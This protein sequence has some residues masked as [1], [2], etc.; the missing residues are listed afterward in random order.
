M[1]NTTLEQQ[2]ITFIVSD[3]SNGIKNLIDTGFNL[4]TTLL[5]TYMTPL[6]FAAS[7]NSLKSVETLIKL[8]ANINVKDNTIIN[9]DESNIDKKSLEILKKY[10][11]DGK[12]CDGFSVL[13]LSILRKH[14]K[15]ANMLIE[16]GADINYK[17]QDLMNP[18]IAAAVVDNVEIAEK[19]LFSSGYISEKRIIHSLFLP[20]M[21]ISNNSFHF[22]DFYL[23][24]VRITSS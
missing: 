17:R 12:I 13:E 21:A 9:I 16:S 23:K 7:N 15:I 20:L 10:K 3:D 4:E 11:F 8:G 18:L 1:K 2:M 14:N 6:M 24:N 5:D 22:L 19:L